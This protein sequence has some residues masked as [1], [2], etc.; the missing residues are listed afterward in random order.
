MDIIIVVAGIILLLTGIAGSLLPALPGPPI[1]FFSLPILFWHSNELTHPSNS[2]LI[3][4]AIAVVV[5]TV[6]D[7][8]LPIWGTKKFGGSDAGKRGSMVGLVLGL[9]F[10]IFG[11]LSIIIMPFIGAIV[12]ELLAGKDTKV[13]LRSGLGSFLGFVAGSILKLGVVGY[14]AY[15]FVKLLWT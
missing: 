13:A 10:S 3:G 9:F 7:Y 12:G 8:F 15:W 6:I 14:M 5:I 2:L 11:A 1:A 4:A